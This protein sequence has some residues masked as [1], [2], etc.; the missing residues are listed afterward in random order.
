MS[1]NLGDP[2]SLV[3]VPLGSHLDARCSVSGQ[4][5]TIAAL[6]DKVHAQPDKKRRKI[7]SSYIGHEANK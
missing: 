4:F 5:R 3:G 6:T 7:Q 1:G 2:N